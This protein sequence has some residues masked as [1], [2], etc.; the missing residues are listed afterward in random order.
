M[1]VENICSIMGRAAFHTPS[2]NFRRS[3]NRSAHCSLGLFWAK[4]LDKPKLFARQLSDLIGILY[5]EDKRDRVLISG[6][7][8]IYSKGNIWIA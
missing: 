2:F 5:C 3:G 7:A 1:A 4:R 6:E 8:V